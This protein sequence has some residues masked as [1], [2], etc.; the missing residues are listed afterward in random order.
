MATK[1]KTISDALK[2]MHKTVPAKQMPKPESGKAGITDPGTTL[3]VR[4]S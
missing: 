4:D 3:G 1:K 2:Q